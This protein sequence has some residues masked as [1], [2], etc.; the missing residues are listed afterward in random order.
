MVL[1]KRDN[2]L[3]LFLII[4]SISLRVDAAPSRKK[5]TRASGM[6]SLLHIFPP[7][8]DR[9]DA[10]FFAPTCTPSPP[11]THTPP[12]DELDDE[13][14]DRHVRAPGLK[15]STKPISGIRTKAKVTKCRDGSAAGVEKSKHKISAS[16]NDNISE[17]SG[18]ESSP[19]SNHET[20]VTNKTLASAA[21]VTFE[22]GQEDG[23]V[24]HIGGNAN[25]VENAPLVNPEGPVTLYYDDI[26]NFYTA[27]ET[28]PDANPSD[29]GFTQV[30]HGATAG[31]ES[32]AIATVEGNDMLETNGDESDGLDNLDKSGGS[33]RGYVLGSLCLVFCRLA[34]TYM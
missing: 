14:A 16:A 22:Y 10:E 28:P 8:G 34:I 1:A 7:R 12:R 24:T 21:G 30:V 20:N 26:G 4:G 15:G 27:E 13:P 29:T 5:G 23:S 3:A 6:R 17:V 18:E 25:E 33:P 9:P 32:F 31:M 2:L 11:L 19:P